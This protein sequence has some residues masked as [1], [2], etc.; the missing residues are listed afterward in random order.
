MQRVDHIVGNQPD[1]EMDNVADW[2]VRLESH[3]ISFIFFESYNLY[4]NGLNFSGTLKR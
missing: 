3:S 1:L 4:L 2:S